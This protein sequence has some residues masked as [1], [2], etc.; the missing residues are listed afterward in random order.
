MA[1]GLEPTS[2]DSKS[3]ILPLDEAIT[4]RSVE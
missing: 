2:A 1:A 4:A 3:A